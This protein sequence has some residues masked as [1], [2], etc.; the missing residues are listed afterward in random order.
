MQGEGRLT[1]TDEQHRGPLLTSLWRINSGFLCTR[2]G[3]TTDLET[4]LEC[5]A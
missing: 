5:S 2:A 3:D 1:H 4:G